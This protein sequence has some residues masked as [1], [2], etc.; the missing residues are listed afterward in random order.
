[1][2]ICGLGLQVQPMLLFKFDFL[3]FIC[4]TV[5]LLFE[6]VPGIALGLIE[7]VLKV[8]ENSLFCT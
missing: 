7:F 1:M 4:H 8:T 2:L 3:V 6:V 5:F